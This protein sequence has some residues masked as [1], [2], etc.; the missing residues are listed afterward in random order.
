MYFIVDFII[1]YVILIIKVFLLYISRHFCYNR[2]YFHN[3][4]KN[5][6]VV[7]YVARHTTLPVQKHSR[8]RMRGNMNKKKAVVSLG[9]DALGYT[10]VEQ[11]DA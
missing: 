3:K 7:P 11:W 2:A 9:H 4:E 10:T 5:T 8:F 1:L 6:I